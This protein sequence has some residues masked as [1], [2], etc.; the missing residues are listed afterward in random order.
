[1]SSAGKQTQ[2][3]SCSPYSAT[4]P[5]SFITLLAPCGWELYFLAIAVRT[6]D[7]M[8]KFQLAPYL[9]PPLNWV[10][11]SKQFQRGVSDAKANNLCQGSCTSGTQLVPG[12]QQGLSKFP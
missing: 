2:A 4:F 1:M 7:S 5:A 11:S 12:R 3:S 8:H 9:T 10:P 6:A